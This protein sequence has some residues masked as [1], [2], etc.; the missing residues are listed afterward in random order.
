VSLDNANVVIDR[1]THQPK[2][3]NNILG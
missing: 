1:M 2:Y 3:G